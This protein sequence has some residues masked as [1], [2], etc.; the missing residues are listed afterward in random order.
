MK[1]EFSFY[2]FAGIIVPSVTF[3]FCMQLLIE[4]ETG[5]QIINFAS[6]GESI[7][8]LI[9]AY[10]FGHILQGMGNAYEWI[11]WRKLYGGMPSN[12]ITKATRF[13]SKL[14][15]DDFK[16]KLL[17][18]LYAK[19]GEVPKKD[20]GRDAYKAVEY[21]GKSQRAD[22]FNGNYSLFRGLVIAF[23]GVTIATVNFFGWRYS[24][25]P[26]LCVIICHIRMVRF[27]KYYASD[28]YRT[29]FNL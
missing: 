24:I 3:L 13:N 17:A 10:A 29:Y 16:N 26:F 15:D 2:E 23:I 7:A 12:W 9:V 8:F 19:F 22:I 14:L 28:V 25:F 5:K 11:L 1:K 6:L 4:I 27:A 18:K 20:Y 21:A